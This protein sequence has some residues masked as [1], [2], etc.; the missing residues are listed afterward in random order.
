VENIEVPSY[1][2]NHN[3]YNN[4]Y[5]LIDLILKKPI[6]TEDDELKKKNIICLYCEK[7]PICPI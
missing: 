4:Q 3:T 1:D 7:S 2:L 5:D 6:I